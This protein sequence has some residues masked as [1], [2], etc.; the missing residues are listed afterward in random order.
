MQ[1]F[2]VSTLE[3][4]NDGNHDAGNLSLREAIALAN[5]QE[6]ADTITFDTNLSGG[7]IALTQTVSTPRGEG[8]FN[9]DLEITDS[10]NI[11]G[12]GANNLTIDGLSSGNGIFNIGG[13]NTNVSLEGLTITNGFDE[14]FFFMDAGVGGAIKFSGDNLTVKDSVFSNNKADFGGAIS[15]SGHVNKLWRI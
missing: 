15:S 1:E 12:L 10:L 11:V 5:E 3:D 7:T 14:R 2:I 13:E 9:Q 6:G 4:E 8:E